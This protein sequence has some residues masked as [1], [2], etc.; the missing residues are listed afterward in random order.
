MDKNK[1]KKNNSYDAGA[2]DFLATKYGYQKMYIRQ[3]LRGDSKS[4]ASDE[5]R[6]EYKVIVQN[7]EARKKANV[8]TIE[9]ILNNN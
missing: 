5:I 1:V 2:I 7:S 4:Q 3:C 6:A 8:K 9:E